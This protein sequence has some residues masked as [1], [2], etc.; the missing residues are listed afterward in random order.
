MAP[1]RRLDDYDARSDPPGLALW[2]ET[3]PDEGK[4]YKTGAI[5]QLTAMWDEGLP[6]DDVSGQLRRVEAE[7]TSDRHQIWIDEDSFQEVRQAN[8]L[9]MG[10]W[11]TPGDHFVVRREDGGVE[12]TGKQTTSDISWE[13]TVSFESPD[14]R[15][16]VMRPGYSDTSADVVSDGEALAEGCTFA[17]C[18]PDD[19]G[20]TCEAAWVHGD[21]SLVMSIVMYAYFPGADVMALLHDGLPAVLASIAT[22]EGL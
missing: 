12:F 1:T 16:Q 11:G 13:W 18:A 4:L 6:V 20:Q 10:A 22:F 15:E 9:N 2:I 14:L 17:A 5:E 3:Y 19:E 7:L 8:L 21:T